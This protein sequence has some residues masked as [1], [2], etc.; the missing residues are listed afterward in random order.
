MART[1]EVRDPT[2]A[3]LDECIDELTAWGFDPAEE[4]SLSH[5]ANWL[6][7]LGNNPDFLG[8]ALIAMLSGQGSVAAGTPLPQGA[9][10][11]RVV[12]ARPQ[13]GNFIL[14]ADIWPSA[15]DQVLRA[16]SPQALGYGFVHNHNADFLTLGYFGPGC[17]VDDYTCDLQA[18]SGWRGEP[19]LLRPLGRY[20][21]RA[22][23]MVHYR[24]GAD[25][26][27]LH[28]PATLSATLT[29]THLHGA[30]SWDSH[31]VFEPEPGSAGS[32]RVA[33]VLGQ[34]PS[35]TFLRLAVALGGD[36]ARDLAFRFGLQHPSDRMRLTAWHALAGAAP[37]EAA[38]DAI[39]QEAEGSG[40]R[41][42]AEVAKRQRS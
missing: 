42:V 19:V 10:T 38:R 3:S 22:G 16:G 32:F 25:V 37:G 28:P 30:G 6:K 2:P 12:L 21:M 20:R 24:P 23:R 9:G 18:L 7:R 40:S 8:D 26:H 13:R 1:I 15:T 11:N 4:S 39:W 14:T 31:Y 41:L 33:R 17:E 34:G 5:A 35:E 29:L 36:E 27:C